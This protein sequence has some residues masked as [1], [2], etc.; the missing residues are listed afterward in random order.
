[1][2]LSHLPSSVKTLRR[3]L[4]FRICFV[5]LSPV[6]SVH[7]GGIILVDISFAIK[8]PILLSYPI[9]NRRIFCTTNLEW[10]R[11]L[12]GRCY[13]F[14]PLF[15]SATLWQH[16]RKIWHD[17]SEIEMV[18]FGS[19]FEPK[20][21]HAVEKRLPTDSADEAFYGCYYDEN[22]TEVWIF[23]Q[24]ISYTPNIFMTRWANIIY[25]IIANVS[26]T[27]RHTYATSLLE[28][29]AQ[30]IIRIWNQAESVNKLKTPRAEF[31]SSIMKFWISNFSLLLWFSA[32]FCK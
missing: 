32:S 11:F 1:M 4:V 8:Q 24:N 5:L 12:L 3:Y 14:C 23:Y 27:V 31:G 25:M 30:H 29:V 16:H 21:I 18:L 6:R 28:S 26:V 2:S 9:R 10:R 15:K 13:V 17:V 20:T 7:L 22:V 19:H